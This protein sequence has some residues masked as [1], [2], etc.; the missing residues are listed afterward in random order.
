MYHLSD[1]NPSMNPP[2]EFELSLPLRCRPLVNGVDC[3]GGDID[4]FALCDTGDDE[5]D[6]LGKCGP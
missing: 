6:D 2:E 4:I 3:P 5:P 1:P